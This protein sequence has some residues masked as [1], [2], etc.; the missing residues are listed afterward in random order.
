MPIQRWYVYNVRF[1]FKYT[2]LNVCNINVCQF[3]LFKLFKAVVLILIKI[4]KNRLVHQNTIKIV[5]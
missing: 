1:I 2:H 4:N 5:P 3:I